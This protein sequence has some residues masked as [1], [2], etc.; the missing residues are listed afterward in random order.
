MSELTIEERL[1]ALEQIAAGVPEREYKVQ[2]LQK[3]GTQIIDTLGHVVEIIEALQEQ[4]G[5]CSGLQAE[6]QQQTVA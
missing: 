2:T 6:S 1:K 3:K 4:I 5:D